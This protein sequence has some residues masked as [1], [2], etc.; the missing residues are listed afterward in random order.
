VLKIGIEPSEI[1][2]HLLLI[3]YKQDRL[4]TVLRLVVPIMPGRLNSLYDLQ[5]IILSFIVS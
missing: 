2:E 3:Y 1:V 4:P 5:G